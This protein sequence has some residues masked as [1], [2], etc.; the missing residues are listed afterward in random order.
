MRGR[1]NVSAEILIKIAPHLGLSRNLLFEKA[2]W[3]ENRMVVD[4]PERL[5][6][7]LNSYDSPPDITEEEIIHLKNYN[8]NYARRLEEYRNYPVNYICKT[9]L[10]WPLFL[11]EEV[12]KYVKYL[13]TMKEGDKTDED[14]QPS[15][16]V[17]Q[18]DAKD[19]PQST[20]LGVWSE[21]SD[22]AAECGTPYP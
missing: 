15:A 8:D 5:V 17:E 9:L 14:R 13:D 7:F 3:L 20:R 10:K 22:R 21:E 16:P 4:C 1:A 19:Q 12:A 6:R 2:G 18:A 11:Q